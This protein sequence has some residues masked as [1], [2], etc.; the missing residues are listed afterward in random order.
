MIHEKYTLSKHLFDNTTTKDL[1]FFLIFS[2][3]SV[4]I[5]RKRES[6]MPVLLHHILSKILPA[7]KIK[8][9]SSRKSLS[10]SAVRWYENLNTHK[11]YESIL[12]QRRIFFPVPLIGRNRR[13]RP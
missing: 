1:N 3:Y 13:I 4:N 2:F 10:V 5:G 7:R 6:I 8:Y 9:L 11:E 12:N